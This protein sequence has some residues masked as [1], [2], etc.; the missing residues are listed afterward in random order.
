MIEYEQRPDGV[1]YF[2]ADL[3]KD[4]DGIVAEME[5]IPEQHVLGGEVR[6]RLR[7]GASDEQIADY[8]GIL[9]EVRM[10][11]L[12]LT[13]AKLKTVESN[14]QWRGEMLALGAWYLVEL[15]ISQIMIGS[16]LVVNEERLASIG[17]RVGHSRLEEFLRSGQ[18]HL[19]GGLKLEIKYDHCEDEVGGSLLETKIISADGDEATLA[20]VIWRGIAGGVE[21]Y[22]H[23]TEI[24]AKEH[25]AQLARDERTENEYV[26]KAMVEG[27]MGE[28][29]PE[30]VL[31][32]DLELAMTL[33]TAR[34]LRQRY[35]GLGGIRV[36]MAEEILLREVTLKDEMLLG[37]VRDWMRF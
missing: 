16:K 21:L 37:P 19:Q 6:I 15:G 2:Q 33:M 9:A 13:Q 24:G 18:A 27:A 3:I 4:W 34:L 5:Y 30:R 8:H 23:R 31:M 29:K 7:D 22:V 17:E 11:A 10:P 35:R 1:R 25:W 12:G 14:P 20:G 32:D 36:F 26:L 28:V